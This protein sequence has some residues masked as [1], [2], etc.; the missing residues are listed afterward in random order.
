MQARFTELIHKCDLTTTKVLQRV[1]KRQE[2]FAGGHKFHIWQEEYF[3]FKKPTQK[4][5]LAL[6]QFKTFFAIKAI[7]AKRRSLRPKH[8]S[9]L[10]RVEILELTRWTFLLPIYFKLVTI[11]N[12]ML[13]IKDVIPM[14]KFIYYKSSNLIG[15][16]FKK[17]SPK[18]FTLKK[19][20]FIKFF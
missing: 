19:Q 20:S 11:F 9:V 7:L 17:K 2:H 13:N 10:L 18:F 3:R 5:S 6:N 15:F 1:V 12:I 14:M 16:I 8:P 4:I